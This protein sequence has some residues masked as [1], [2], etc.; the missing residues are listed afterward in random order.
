MKARLKYI[1][2]FFIIIITTFLM[3]K[4]V[5]M[6]YNSGSNDFGVAD[7]FTVLWRGLP[8]D[9]STASYM[10]SVP[11]LIS[12]VSLWVGGRWP[13]LAT[14]TYCYIIAPL[15]AL[16]VVTDTVLYKFWQFKLDATIFNYIDDL[17]GVTSSV[18][19]WFV[20]IAILAIAAI[21]A[22]TLLA[23]RRVWIAARRLEPVARH[24]RDLI[25]LL[26]VGGV[27]FLLGR[28][29]IGRSTMNVGYVYYSQ[30]QF[31]NH[32][33]VNPVFSLLSSSFKVQDFEEL[34]H[35]YDTATCDSI[36]AQMHYE[37]L[38]V[39]TDTLLTTT[40]P[41]ILLIVMEGCGSVFF[42][43][44]ITPNLCRLADEGIYFSRCYANSFR[45]DR[46]LVSTL[47]GYPAF[48]DISVM[49]LAEKARTLPSIARTL[50]ANGYTT[51]FLYG[52]DINFTNTKGYLLSTGYQQVRG[53][54]TF[55]ASVRHSH[56]WGVQDHIVLDTLYNMF[57]SLTLQ[58][59]RAARQ[60]SRHRRGLA[61]RS[62][63]SEAARFI[64]CLTLSSHEDWQVP[65]RRITDDQIANSMAYLDDSIGKLVARLKA[66]PMWGNLL[67]IILSDHSISYPAGITE[68]NPERN[69]IPVIWTG[70]AVSGPRR[71]DALC[72]QTDLAATLLGQLRL[73][74]A[75]FTFSRDVLSS[76]YSYPC[77]VHTFSGGITLIDTAGH[78]VRE[79]GVNSENSGA[80]KEKSLYRKAKA[81][82]QKTM[83]DFAER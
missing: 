51:D 32:S 41:D 38:S 63:E 31:L 74:H 64:T 73:T 26:L 29:G 65:Y 19:A 42:T 35:F 56:S 11:L 82:L 9:L 27:L 53:Y 1:G 25:I 44:T 28:G 54:E 75:D 78:V 5:F 23:L 58:G 2:L 8:L 80:K 57:Q 67:L 45:T 14:K 22:L 15:L 47:S 77:A 24:I 62:R 7:V 50:A 83:Q 3:I 66:S 76:S 37:T 71:I 68:A 13:Q 52:G 39:D 49:K 61:L 34:Y 48:P 59:S 60:W 30:N 17:Q 20:I 12:I 69:R 10:T 79:L 72:N 6:L 21:A 33:A 46:G 40:R 81:Y 36:F 18:S 16:I 4:V 70:G 43:P 55:P